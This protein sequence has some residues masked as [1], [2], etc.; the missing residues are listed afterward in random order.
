[1]MLKELW[2]TLAA[3]GELLAS[4]SVHVIAGA[5]VFAFI[6]LHIRWAVRRMRIV[7]ASREAERQ[8][9]AMGRARAK[10]LHTRV[11]SEKKRKEAA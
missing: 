2:V 1:M 4:A 9:Q 3:N 10:A 6:G 11:T 8:L 7:R 5:F